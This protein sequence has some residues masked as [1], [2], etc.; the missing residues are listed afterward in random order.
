MRRFLLLITS[1]LFLWEFGFA[2]TPGN[3]TITV[4]V[5]EQLHMVLIGSVVNYTYNEIDGV[6]GDPPTSTSIF[7]TVDIKANVDWRFTISTL[8][9]E[10]KLR[11]EDSDETLEA[12]RFEYTVTR[13]K[14]NITKGIGVH[15]LFPESLI[16]TEGSMDTKFKLYWQP[17]APYFENIPA[18]DYTIDV[19]YSLTG[20]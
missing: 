4:L 6:R 16:P 11:K 12:S 8:N 17:N 15:K 19:V 5:P 3:G 9:G 18:G 1:V 10:S 14:G 2:Q 13:M 7:N 20:R